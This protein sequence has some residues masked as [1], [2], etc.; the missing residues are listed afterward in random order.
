MAVGLTIGLFF[1]ILLLGGLLVSAFI[2]LTWLL[3]T[4]AALV[5]AQIY[6][7][8][9]GGV[10]LPVAAV[11]ALGLWRFFR[12]KWVLEHPWIF[13]ALGLF[14][15]QA[16]ALIWSPNPM[17]AIRGNIYLLP[18]VFVACAI[19]SDHSDGKKATTQA[20]TA[21]VLASIPQAI[22]VMIFRVLPN[23]EGMFLSSAIAAKFVSANALADVAAGGYPVLDVAKSGG[24]FLN[25]NVAAVFM[26]VTGFIALAFSETTRQSWFK[27]VAVLNFVAV[28]FAGSKAAILIG[29][30]LFMALLFVKIVRQGGVSLMGVFVTTASVSILIP[31]L[32]FAWLHFRQSDLLAHSVL[33]LESRF[34]MWGFAWQAFTEHP[35]TGLGF[36]GW[37]LEWPRYALAFGLN[38]QFPPHNSLLNHFIQS[39]LL[40]L[41]ASLAFA[42]A[43]LAV[44]IRARRLAQDAREKSSAEFLLA[45]LVW[46]FSQSLA[47][48]YG[49]IG[50]VHLTILL[51]VTVASF[52]KLHSKVSPD[53]Q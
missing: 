37:E 10:T 32:L 25:A 44:P 31:V 38:P 30:A 42:L 34:P 40:G 36:G 7:I 9:A 52:V 33:T 12:V 24:F 21:L 13:A 50:E 35:W 17:L 4:S 45:A 49:F 23:V 5:T 41:L 15:A 11:A 27:W 3:T 39:G 1:G 22:L 43:M 2:P 46:Y 47:E 28:F 20:V 26:G 14:V 8:P 6:L 18:F 29:C 16:A 53:F 51:A 48:N 19:L